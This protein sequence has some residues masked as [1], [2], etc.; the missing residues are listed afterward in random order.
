MDHLPEFLSPN[1]LAD[2]LQTD[3]QRLATMRMN[4]TGP[5]F[6]RTGRLVR[7]RRRDVE[8]W[9]DANIRTATADVA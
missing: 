9:I 8:A 2:L 6:F 4:S 5:Q 7:Y 3:M 1:Q